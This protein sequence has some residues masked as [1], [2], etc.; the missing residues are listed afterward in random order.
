MSTHKNECKRDNYERDRQVDREK[1]IQK[2][3]KQKMKTN[4]EDYN[5][6]QIEKR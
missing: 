5:Q 3:D 2:R 6:K 4:I 1:E